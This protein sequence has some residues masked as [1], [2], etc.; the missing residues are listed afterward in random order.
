MDAHRD[1]RLVII[2]DG[3]L[4][5]SLEDLVRSLGCG[6]RVTLLGARDDVPDLLPHFDLFVLPSLSEGLPLAVLEA[7]ACAIPVIATRVGDLPHVVQD[8]K[9]GLTVPPGDP[10]ALLAALRAILDRPEWGTRLGAA[11][12]LLVENRFNLVHTVQG[13][14]ALYDSVA[15]RTGPPDPSSSQLHHAAS[16]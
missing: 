8:A 12:H 10:Q 3:S 2:G 14:Q 16:R 6:D 4:R 1:T 11:A 5:H 15:R 13:Y 7:M 9:T